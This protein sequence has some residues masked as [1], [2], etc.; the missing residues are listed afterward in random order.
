MKIENGRVTILC[1]ASIKKD[2]A[3]TKGVPIMNG[4]TIF[5]TQT[6]QNKISSTNVSVQSCRLQNKYDKYWTKY[7]SC[8]CCPICLF[9]IHL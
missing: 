3:Q 5:I 8:S 6:L 4:P 9:S 2:S 7:P 1:R